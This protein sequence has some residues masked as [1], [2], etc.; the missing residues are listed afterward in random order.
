MASTKCTTY[1]RES[2]ELNNQ[3]TLIIPIGAC[4]Y[5]ELCSAI[6]ILQVCNILPRKVIYVLKFEQPIKVLLVEI[7][8]LNK[9]LL[10]YVTSH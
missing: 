4:Y 10:H 6:T 3:C 1:Y 7:E 8:L 2:N 5:L 9:M